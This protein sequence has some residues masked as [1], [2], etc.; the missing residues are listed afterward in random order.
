MPGRIRK[1]YAVS[2]NLFWRSNVE[3]QASVILKNNKGQI[4]SMSVGITEW[5]PVFYLEIIGEKGYIQV[6]GLGRKYGGKEL[7]ILGLKNKDGNVTEEVI[8]CD[9][10]PENALEVLLSE[11]ITSIE[12]GKMSGPTGEDALQV[13]QIV[14]KTYKILEKK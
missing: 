12:T 5:K 2:Q 4:A 11:F 1:L 8:E 14:E 9:P 10:E 3:E 6:Q 13:L 7:F